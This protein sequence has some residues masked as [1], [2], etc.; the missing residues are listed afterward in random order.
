MRSVLTSRD[1]IN[2]P[3][4]AVLSSVHKSNNVISGDRQKPNEEVIQRQPFESSNDYMRYHF[5]APLNNNNATPAPYMG[6]TFQAQNCPSNACQVSFT[7]NHAHGFT[8]GSSS[9][10]FVEIE[11]GYNHSQCAPC[12]RLR[13]IQILRSTTLSQ[14]QVQTANPAHP[15]RQI[16][17]GVSR[18]STLTGS[19]GW[20]IDSI[21]S[22]DEVQGF[23]VGQ[24]E[25]AFYE[26]NPGHDHRTGTATQTAI[27][28][29]APASANVNSGKEFWS[30]LVCENDS[31]NQRNVVGGVSWGYMK[32]PNS[33][34][35]FQPSLPVAICGPNQELRDADGRWTALDHEPSRI[36]YP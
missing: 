13:W 9:G 26:N 14:G 27:L 15:A 6:Q 7:F 5:N 29:D 16:R 12:D 36:N 8:Q 25:N 33:G 24:S 32:H 3:K 10:M 17:A 30:F 35:S 20:R 23:N 28:R 22:N 4:P 18:N 2:K 1:S 19:A 11:A 21:L 31:T 34:F